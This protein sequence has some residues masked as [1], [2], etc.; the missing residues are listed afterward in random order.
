M[1]SKLYY[2]YKHVSGLYCYSANSTLCQ[3]QC[4]MISLWC[5]VCLLLLDVTLPVSCVVSS[6]SGSSS[7]SGEQCKYL[8]LSL[9]DTIVTVYL[10][11]IL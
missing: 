10:T 6:D 8:D 1:E 7:G 9:Y 4:T 3:F 5:A 2:V 11:M